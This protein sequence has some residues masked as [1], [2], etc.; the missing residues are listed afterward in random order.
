MS[1]REPVETEQLTG[2]LPE[3][4]AFEREYPGS[5]FVSSAL[6]RALERMGSLMEAQFGAVFRRFG[7]SHAAGNALAVIEGAGAPITPGEISAAMHI[8]SGS[9]TSLLDTL[10]KQ[11]LVRRFAHGEDR[12]KVLVDITPEG[13]QLLDEALPAIQLVARDLL[14]GLD[15]DEQLTLYE[16]IQRTHMSVMAH[17]PGVIPSA[18][19]VR[20]K[21]L[22]RS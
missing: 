3:A 12:R 7:L 19:R 1:E 14:K 22:D 21:R 6:A 4:K 13:Q 18:K 2:R 5:K 9:I 16:L 17:D 11:D 15:D 8:T 10:E 20:P